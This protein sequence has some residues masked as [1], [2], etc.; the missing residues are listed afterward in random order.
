MKKLIK[1][2][3]FKKIED[4]II[5]IMRKKNIKHNRVKRQFLVDGN[6]I[7]TNTF[8]QELEEKYFKNIFNSRMYKSWNNIKNRIDQNNLTKNL[9]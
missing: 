1:Q 6:Y 8:I 4:K 2:K 7:L 5:K 3:D 9:I